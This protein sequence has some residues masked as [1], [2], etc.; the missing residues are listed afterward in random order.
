LEGDV[1]VACAVGAGGFGELGGAVVEVGGGLVLGV[2]AFGGVF[3]GR[4][5]VGGGVVG[6]GGLGGGEVEVV[7][8]PGV[9]GVD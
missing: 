4:E 1:E 9:E 5:D 8:G 3:G 6:L 2:G 7:L